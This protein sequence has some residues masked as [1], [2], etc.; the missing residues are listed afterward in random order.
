MNRESTTQRHPKRIRRGDISKEG[1]LIVLALAAVGGFAW[2]QYRH[3]NPAAMVRLVQLRAVDCDVVDFERFCRMLGTPGAMGTMPS[4]IGVMSRAEGG[5]GLA[6]LSSGAPPAGARAVVVWDDVK[7]PFLLVRIAMRQEFL[8]KNRASR[9]VWN[10]FKSDDFLLQRGA[11]MSNPVL[12]LGGTLKKGGSEN[13]ASLK[14]EGVTVEESGEGGKA[15]FRV[16]GDDGVGTLATKGDEDFIRQ[17]LSVRLPMHPP[18][19]LKDDVWIAS[20]EFRREEGWSDLEIA[21]L[22]PAPKGTGELKLTCFQDDEHVLTL[23]P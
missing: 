21:L 9:G 1:I 8:D 2:T 13:A 18:K 5:G 19:S 7:A 17:P 12:L 16:S 20:Q 15:S 10:S 11:A 23:S 4:A 6:A 3:A 22:F 14:L